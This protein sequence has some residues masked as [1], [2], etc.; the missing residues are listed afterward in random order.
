MGIV[1][2]LGIAFVGFAELTGLP[3]LYVNA[4]ALVL[5]VSLP[6]MFFTR[7]ADE[8]TLSL[9]S[10]GTNAA[11]AIVIVWLVGAPAI[12]GFFDGLFGIEG[13]QDFPDRGAS[14]AALFAFYLAF[15]GKRLLGAL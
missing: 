2:L 6:I 5:I 9:W 4:A 7:K 11:F 10:S 3:R 12:E 13:G 14:V 1:G 8:Y 15:N